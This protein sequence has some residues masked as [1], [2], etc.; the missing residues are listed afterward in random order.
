MDT[1]ICIYTTVLLMFCAFLKSIYKAPGN[2]YYCC[3]GDTTFTVLNTKPIHYQSPDLGAD[4]IWKSRI[5][6]PRLIQCLL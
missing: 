4:F 2:G 6:F 1:F 5:L 3:D